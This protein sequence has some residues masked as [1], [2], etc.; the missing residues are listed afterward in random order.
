MRVILEKLSPQRNHSR[1]NGPAP[2]LLFIIFFFVGIA[3]IFAAIYFA[4]DTSK[5]L[6]EGT[7]T[8]GVVVE[9]VEIVDKD[10]NFQRRKYNRI[11]ISTGSDSNHKIGYNYSYAPKVEFLDGAGKKFAFQSSMSSSPP[12][13]SLGEQVDVIYPKD[14]PQTAKI[15]STMSLWGL[16]IILG[17]M[18][19]VFMVIGFIGFISVSGVLLLS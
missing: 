15:K 11:E 10:T 9:L 18:G 8:K 17:G 4:L 5:L 12:S 13:F 1:N 7:I 2:K 3:A 6:K 16:S 14:N 19:L